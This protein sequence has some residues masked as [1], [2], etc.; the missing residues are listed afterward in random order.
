[1]SVL[2]SHI[3]SSKAPC[4]LQFSDMLEMLN[5]APQENH[6]NRLTQPKSCSAPSTTDPAAPATSAAT[7]QPAAP[8]ESI[9]SAIQPAAPVGRQLPAAPPPASI[10]KPNFLPWPHV[11]APDCPGGWAPGA[12]A[13]LARGPGPR[14]CSCPCLGL[15]SGQ[16][17]LHWSWTAWGV[18][19]PCRSGQQQVQRRARKRRL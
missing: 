1:M 19:Q 11:A 3:I 13:C 17:G 6:Q 15:P 10:P 7:E 5:F 2:I 12:F 14:R 8:A 9:T 16:Q 18:P 4:I